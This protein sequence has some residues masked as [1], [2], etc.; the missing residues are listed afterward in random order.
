MK[1]ISKKTSSFLRAATCAVLVAA[2]SLPAFAVGETLES[3]ALAKVTELQTTATTI[4]LAILG[5]VGAFAIFKL[6]KRALAKA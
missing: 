2:S 5:I 4:L 6:V 3:E 1:Q